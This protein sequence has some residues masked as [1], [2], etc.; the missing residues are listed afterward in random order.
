M[1]KKELS[2]N[3]VQSVSQLKLLHISLMSCSAFHDKVH[4]HQ[5]VMIMYKETC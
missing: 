5:E 3:S 2:S 1:M 4:E